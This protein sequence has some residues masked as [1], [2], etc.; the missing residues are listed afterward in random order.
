MV[1]LINNRGKQWESFIAGA[2]KGFAFNGDIFL[3]K[4][5]LY[6]TLVEAIHANLLRKLL[7]QLNG[8]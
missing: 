2:V 1:E 7:A 8:P 4:K 6:D 3:E 5:S